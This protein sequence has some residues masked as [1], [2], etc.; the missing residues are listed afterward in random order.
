MGKHLHKLRGTRFSG[1]YCFFFITKIL[2]DEQMTCMSLQKYWRQ[3]LTSEKYQKYS[4]SRYVL[5]ERY[6]FFSFFPFQVYSSWTTSC[7]MRNACKQILLSHVLWVFVYVC[8]A[9]C[10]AS[11]NRENVVTTTTKILDVKTKGNFTIS[12]FLLSL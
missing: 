12:S 10:Y 7:V 5:V 3:I 2:N 9:V 11:E 4:K 6:L 1:N 8:S